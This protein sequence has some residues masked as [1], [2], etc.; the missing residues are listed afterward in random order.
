MHPTMFL[1]MQKLSDTLVNYWKSVDCN[2]VSNLQIS[3]T[4]TSCTVSVSIYP[5]YHSLGDGEC[6][7][8]V[9]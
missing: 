2:V 4:I 7:S 5:N 6:R 1:K 3:V 8:S 9:N